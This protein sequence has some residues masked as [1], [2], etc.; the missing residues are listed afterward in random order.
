MI[1]QDFLERMIRQIAETIAAA[2][3]LAKE[4]KHEQA[5]TSVEDAYRTYLGMP[6]TMVDR[7][8]PATVVSTFGPEKAIVIAALLDGEAKIDASRA[9]ELTA[10]ANAI[11]AAI[12]L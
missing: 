8:D 6:K 5:I 3:R 11:R 10:R 1:R 9:A 4:G 2:L 7:L 12:G